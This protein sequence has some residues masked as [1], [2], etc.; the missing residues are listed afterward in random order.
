V[1][2]GKDTNAN[3]IGNVVF[4]WGL[5]RIVAYAVGAT[6]VGFGLYERKT[7]IKGLKEERDRNQRYEEIADPDRTSS[8]LVDGGLVPDD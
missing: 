6:G 1:L 2:A 5:D 3:I 7:R 8:G 4:D